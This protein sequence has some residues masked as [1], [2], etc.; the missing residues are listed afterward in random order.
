MKK[1]KV[2]SFV[3]KYMQL[4]T[5]DDH[6]ELNQS[7]KKLYA[8]CHLWILDLVLIHKIMYAYGT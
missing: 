4:A 3:R 1:S 8:F 7:K 5:R 6:F 2:R